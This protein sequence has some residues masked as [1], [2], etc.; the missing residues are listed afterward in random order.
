MRTHLGKEDLER[1]E[2]TL[3]AGSVPAQAL[4]DD[5]AA[6]AYAALSHATGAMAAQLE[7]A[8]ANLVTSRLTRQR[9]PGSKWARRGCGTQIEGEPSQGMLDCG[10]GAIAPETERFLY[11]YA[12]EKSSR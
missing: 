4:L 3:A 2:R 9:I 1:L 6:V 5:G 12:V 8:L 11:F 10:M 7:S